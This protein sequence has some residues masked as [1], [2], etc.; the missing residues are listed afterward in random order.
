MV[1]AC[2]GWACSYK[3]CLGSSMGL[4]P[5]L[6]IQKPVFLRNSNPYSICQ[7]AI[8]SNS[9]IRVIHKYDY[10]HYYTH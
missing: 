10:Y 4:R 5:V 6:T 2:Y 8:N 9:A 3:A 7:S 1:Q